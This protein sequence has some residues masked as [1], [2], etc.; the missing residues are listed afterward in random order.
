MTT[1]S[2]PAPVSAEQFHLAALELLSSGHVE[3]AVRSL[4]RA[5]DLDPARAAAWNDLG[6]ILEALGNRRDAI[7]CY[8]RALR[9]QPAMQEPRRNL[10]ALALQA[11]AASPPP[12]PV[13]ARAAAAIAR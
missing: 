8:C 13:S 10:L 12:R 2:H 3:D 1:T 6:V 7:S 9:A 4:R 11:A 5:L